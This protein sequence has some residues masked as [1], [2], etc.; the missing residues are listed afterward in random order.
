MLRY[1]Y[2]YP[3]F[4]GIAGGGGGGGAYQVRMSRRVRPVPG[5]IL[6]P[7][8]LNGFSWFYVHFCVFTPAPTGTTGTTG[9][10]DDGCDGSGSSSSC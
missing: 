8:R 10:G 5:S 6:F 4:F 1:P 7:L 9:G 2:T 3:F